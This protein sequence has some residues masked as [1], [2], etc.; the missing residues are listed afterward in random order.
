MVLPTVMRGFSEAYGSW[1]TICTRRAP[2]TVPV[3]G[4]S[5]HTALASVDLPDPD[6]PTSPTTPPSGISSVTSSTA[7]KAPKRTLRFLMII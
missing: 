6:S 4:T 1:K 7:V 5:P 2:S 3:W